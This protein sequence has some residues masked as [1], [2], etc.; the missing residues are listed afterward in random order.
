MDAP[1]KVPEE[2][3]LTPF[4][5]LRILMDLP[6]ERIANFFSTDTNYQMRTLDNAKL[7]HEVKLFYEAV[8]NGGVDNVVSLAK[9]LPE[10]T[11]MNQP[12]PGSEK[13]VRDLDDDYPPLHISVSL[14]RLDMCR[15]LLDLG[16]DPNLPAGIEGHRPLHLAAVQEVNHDMVQLLLDYGADANGINKQ[17]QINPLLFLLFEGVEEVYQEKKIRALVAHGADVNS[18][19]VFCEEGVL[20][21]SVRILHSKEGRKKHNKYCKTHGN[22]K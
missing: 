21:H 16:A 12:I 18:T 13:D 22:Q 19:S 2:D 11:Y 9:T 3:S 8:L 1:P 15:A 20:L 4:R 14:N 5:R 10:Q 6:K 7:P 17:N